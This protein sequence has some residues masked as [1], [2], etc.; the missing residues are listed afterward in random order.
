M[1]CKK[2]KTKIEEDSRFCPNCGEK[3]K[4]LEIKKDIGRDV[5]ED[6]KKLI[7]TLDLKAK[8]ENEKKYPCPFCNKEISVQTL[9]N[10]ISQSKQND[11]EN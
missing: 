5:I 7:D 4:T 6:L 3:Q 8:K 9:K 2:C 10:K 11:G 1:E